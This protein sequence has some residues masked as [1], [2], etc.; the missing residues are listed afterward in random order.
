M[1][2]RVPLVLGLSGHR[3][4]RTD[5]LEDIR[6]KFLALLDDLAKRFPDTPFVLL[7]G[8]AEGCDQ[9]ASR[10]AFE[11]AF[12]WAR[13]QPLCPWGGRR[14]E[15]MGVLP[16]PRE[17]YRND[18]TE[19]AWK[20]YEEVEQ[21]C[22]VVFELPT[23][24]I[25]EA[26]EESKD[27]EPPQ[28]S[29]SRDA[30]YD[31]LAAFIVDQSHLLIALWNGVDVDKP[32]G[33]ASAVRRR[34]MGRCEV[35]E[36][37]IG[38]PLVSRYVFQQE[39]SSL[40]PHGEPLYRIPTRRQI[41]ETPL[42]CQWDEENRKALE[43]LDEAFRM[44]DSVNAECSPSERELY[45]RP[46]NFKQLQEVAEERATALD[47]LAKKCKQK[48]GREAKKEPAVVMLALLL[49]ALVGAFGDA[50]Y[51][52][53]ES[54]RVQAD[55]G[56]WNLPLTATLVLLLLY[57]GLLTWLVR[58]IRR[59]T[60]H[61]LHG[62]FAL[63]RAG[64]EGIRV[65]TGLLHHG[66]SLQ[67]SHLMSAFDVSVGRPVRQL[68]RGGC[69]ELIVCC[70]LRKQQPLEDV[71]SNG[72]GDWI[73]GQ[74]NYF[75]DAISEDGRRKKLQRRIEKLKVWSR[76]ATLALAFGLL[77]LVLV[78]SWLEIQ[79]LSFWIDLGCLLVALALGFAAVAEL[80]D[81]LEQVGE[82]LESYEPMKKVYELAVK[83][84]RK[85]RN[86]A[87]FEDLR[88]EVVK[89]LAQEATDEFMGWYLV[90]K[91]RRASLRLG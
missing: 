85:D 12:E 14:I 19:E 11:W 52:W 17:W 60:R 22:S 74:F 71:Q 30:F 89:D 38:M 6:A 90:R 45:G 63:A 21:M 2:N 59:P 73:D 44:V 65:Q 16:M 58:M 84:L 39:R 40:L 27:A 82:E 28:S 87:N 26:R 34:T 8:L 9:Y 47:G 80:Q 42:F 57:C 91:Q 61:E 35:A 15:I 41:D 83:R 62:V 3:D 5:S 33:T 20:A 54:W 68:L 50:D 29:L 48:I 36:R 31:Q 32:A 13:S 43:Q 72:S 64:A 78:G 25:S 69:L 4:P 24:A 70:A 7:N 86:A 55:Q 37:M 51:K 67:V 53:S 1:S 10:W 18:F 88:K 66:L 76:R 56:S 75:R 46:M 79:P 81:S 23:Q 49:F 77:A